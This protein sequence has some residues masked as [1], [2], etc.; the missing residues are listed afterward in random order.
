MKKYLNFFWILL[1]FVLLVLVRMFESQLFYD[2]FLNYFK[3]GFYA[4]EV[5]EFNGTRLFL[6]HFF[7]YIINTVISLLLLWIIFKN[8]QFIKVAIV[9]YVILFV[10]LILAYFLLIE[11]KLEEHHLWTFYTRRFLIQPLLVFI[12]IPAFYYQNRFSE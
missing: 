4:N 7:R 6:S 10:I 11:Y 9:L 5:P 12:L 2:P 1:L 3:G 8:G